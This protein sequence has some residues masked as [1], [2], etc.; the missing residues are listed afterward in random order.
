M[1]KQANK[2][3]EY[4]TIDVQQILKALWRKAWLII[5]CGILTAMI[6]FFYS[7]FAITPSYSS[8]VKLYVNNNSFSLGNNTFS[9][10][11]SQISA[12]QSL[13]KTYGEILDSRTTLQRVIEKAG[14]DYTWENISGMIKYES[15]NETE[16]MNVSVVSNDPYE[17]SKIANAIAE[18]LPE[19]IS[20]I[21][22]GA[23][24]EVVDSAI[25]NVNKVA[26]SI[27]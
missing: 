15:A 18:V 7:T 2:N 1:E 22:D 21:I 12:A 17:A 5:V 3:Q 24:M 13:V 25:P 27:M 11:A 10:S 4:Y 8:S 23:S 9:I 16:I 14:V 20:E 26:P 6:G 19:R